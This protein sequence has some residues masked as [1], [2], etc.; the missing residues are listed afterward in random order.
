LTK[1]IL[2]SRFFF[3]LQNKFNLQYYFTNIVELSQYIIAI[4][5]DKDMKKIKNILKQYKNQQKTVPNIQKLR[6]NIFEMDQKK[7]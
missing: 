4:Y 7:K 5:Q 3:Y 1:D 2:F 6:Y